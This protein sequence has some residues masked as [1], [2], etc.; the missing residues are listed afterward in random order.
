M[1]VV[2]SHRRA[3]AKKVLQRLEQLHE[4][5]TTDHGYITVPR[6][7]S[8]VP[9]QETHVVQPVNPLVQAAL[10][11]SAT[12]VTR[13]EYRRPRA[14]VGRLGSVRASLRSRRHNEH[15]PAAWLSIWNEDAEGIG[16]PD[17]DAVQEDTGRP[18]ILTEIDKAVR[19]TLSQRPMS[20]VHEVTILANWQLQQCVQEELD[21]DCNLDSFLTI[22]GSDSH[23]WAASCQEYVETT[24]GI[25]GVQFLHDL[26][27]Q[28]RQRG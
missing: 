22:S 16:L 14:S 20:E 26:G 13:G 6:Q 27:L 19:Q 8:T 18:D 3:T 25:L 15:R 5:A 9:R 7:D 2:D 12:V 21:G 28:L 23:S 24:W 4:K 11:D 1:L 17:I 10:I